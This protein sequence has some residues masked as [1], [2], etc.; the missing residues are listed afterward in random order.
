V[1]RLA[2]AN[3]RDE[4]REGSRKI[5]E[6]NREIFPHPY[7][8][9]GEGLPSHFARHSLVRGGEGRRRLKK[10]LALLKKLIAVTN[11]LLTAL[12]SHRPQ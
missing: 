1:K 9:L 5:E 11:V 4:K 2:G 10:I 6:Q 8:V 7:P 3:V 12:Q